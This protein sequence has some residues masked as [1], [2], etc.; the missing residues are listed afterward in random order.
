MNKNA[1]S[2][3]VLVVAAML[4]M[5]AWPA[6]KLASVQSKP[7]LTMGLSDPGVP[8]MTLPAAQGPG[9]LQP[10]VGYAI[11]SDLSPALR[12]LEPVLPEEGQTIREIPLRP[13]PQSR[14]PGAPTGERDPVVQSWPGAP[15]MPSPLKNWEG[16]NNRN[17]VYPP[18]TQGDI[19]DDPTT[20]KKYYVQWVNLSYAMWDVTGISPTLVLGPV[21]GN[22]LW[23]GFGG[24]CETTNHG[25]P[26]TLFD[27]LAHRWLMSQFSVNGP[28]H[29]CIAISQTGD[30]T[31]AWYRYDFLVHATKMNDYPK[32]G[33]WPDAYYMTV[34]QFNPG[35]AGA[36]VFAFNRAKMLV[37]DPTANFV[38][39]DLY[40]ANPNFGGMLPSDLDGDTPPPAGA[41][42]Y[43]AEVDNGSPD[44]M[45]L[46]KFHTDWTN[47]LSSTFG[48]NGQPNFVVPVADFNPLTS[49]IPQP[50][51]SQRLDSLADRLMHRLAYRNFGDHESLV[52]N[53]TVDA[54]ASRAGVRWY[55]VRDPGETP[56]IYQQ[57]TYAPADTEHRWMGSIAMDHMGN[58]ALGYSVSS[59]SVYPS[60]RYTGR[61][62][63]DPLG[64]LPQGETEIIAGSGVQTGPAGRWGDYSMMGVDPTDDCT[65]WYTQEYIQTTGTASWQTRIAAFKFPNC[66]LGPQGTLRGTVSNASN[67]NPIVGA[68]V[69]AAS[70]PIQTFSTSSGTGGGY[71]IVL[72]VNTYTVTGSAY[73]FRPAAI[74]GVSVVSGTTTTQ[75][76]QLTPVVMRV[77]SGTVTDAT[78]GWSLYAHITIQGDPFNPPPPYN[79][80]WTDPVTGHYSVTLA[81]GIT[82]T[83]NVNA[84]VT[85]Y[86]AAS[87]AVGPL[88]ANRTENFGLTV[89]SV[90]CNAPGYHPTVVYSE[91]FEASNGEYITTTP[92]TTSW[93]W[94]T[95]SAA[96]GLG[97]AHSG[98]KLWATNLTGNYN[99][100]EDG[101]TT[102]PNIDLG[103][104][105]G[106]SLLLSWWQWLQTESC[107]DYASVEV[108]KDGGATWA[109]VYGEVS[110]N[111]DLVWAQHSVTLDPTY[112]VSNF[113]VRF[114]LRTDY[115]VT[116][117]GWY[118]DDV[119]IRSASCIPQTGGLVVGNTFDAN[120]LAPLAGARVSN[121]SGRSTMTLATIDPNVPDSF[122]TMFSPSGSRV[123]T[124]TRTG[125]YVTSIQTPTVV[126]SSTIRQDFNL[127]AG[128]LSYTP[129]SLQ[130]ALTLGSSTSKPFTLTNSGG[131]SATFELIEL[132]KGMGPLG[133]FQKPDLVVKPFKQDRRTAQGLGLPDPPPAPPYAAGDVI[134]SWASGLAAAWGIAYDKNDGTVWVSSPAPSWSGN[135]TIYEFTPAGVQTGRSRL[136]SWNPTYGPADAAFNWNTG[137]LWIMNVDTAGANNC[138]YEIDPASGYTGNRIC[139]GGGFA[140]NQRGLAYDPSTDTW[141]A[142]SWND[143]MIHH[144]DST[145]VMLDEVNVGLGVAGLAYN[146]DTRHLFAIVNAN[147]NPVYVLDAANNYTSLG[148]F[149]I[150]GF[151]ANSGA[152]LEIGCDGH[153]WAVNQTS[154]AVYEVD[155][156]ETTS[157]CARDVPWLSESPISGTLAALANQPIAVT[158]DAS[159]VAQP[160]QY[161]AQLKIKHN[162]P[163]VVTNVPVTLTVPP[164][165]NWGKLTGTVT[166]LARCDAS[167]P[168]LNN[169]TVLFQSSAGMTWT[170]TT[171]AG[172]QYEW[173]MDQANNPLSM[174]VSHAG[175]ITQT[176]TGIAVTAQ[177]TTTQDVSLRLAVPC[178]SVNPAGLNIRGVPGL[179]KT[180][181]LTI[182]NSGGG[183]AD[184]ALWEKSN[185][186]ASPIAVAVFNHITT[187]DISY[188]TGS[189]SNDWSLYQ[190]ILTSDV[191]SRF[192]VTVV[193]NLSPATLTGFDRLILPD[194]AVPDV[195][196]N[197]VSSWFT[198][199][200]RIIAVDSAT[201]YAAYSGFMWP[202]SAGSNGNGVYWDY[203]SGSDDQEVLRFDRI[204]RD[205][206]V[207]Q[208]LSAYGGDSE[209]FAS[210]L[211]GPTLQ[212]TAKHWDHSKVYVASRDVPGKGTI[213][214]LGPYSPLVASNLYALVRNAVAGGTDVDVPWLSE[215]PVSSTVGA[216][217]I[218]PVNITLTALPMMTSGAYTTTLA[219]NT[220]DIGNVRVNIPVTMTIVAPP[221]CSFTSSSPDN[222]GEV[223]SFVNATTG[224]PPISYQWNFGDSSTVSTAANPT[225]RYPHVGLYTVILTATNAVST[226]VC[227]STVSIVNHLIYLPVVLRN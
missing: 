150:P 102:S 200:K 21:N 96:P 97:S 66:A 196:T 182:T 27:P 17:G 22:T 131:A 147:P 136:F 42:N 159:Q 189:N 179:S 75:N 56:V 175:H 223:T 226:D 72:P 50:G 220:G 119:Q 70:S 16:V 188:W 78:T 116:Y 86:N 91:T 215:N 61:L 69:Q 9:F 115:S 109:R 58:M 20:N 144:F 54:G 225:Y 165:A 118:V 68:Q 40:G 38:Y 39:F 211:P 171:D 76:I 152:G 51:T 60:I 65:F 57:G 143:S 37:G 59:N 67:G 141:Y 71:S 137:M 158:F 87:H 43:F 203:G 30:P 173:W 167:G 64:T 176:I 138:I 227:T 15:N 195:Y 112:A 25:D 128:R 48:V 142:G 7:T 73:G 199:G 155:S 193:T 41:P 11:K 29:Q 190:N 123:F 26:I 77:V 53:H 49:L 214:V 13:L 224:D 146:P 90:T 204:T 3:N 33:V 166:G 88:T 83:F 127:P 32:F 209:M 93:A 46:W 192:V 145:G 208:V 6:P 124:A 178:V 170:L 183:P 105:A 169:A 12:D 205:Y 1:I 8:P 34:N 106:Q 101:Y 213:V 55:E 217:A 129:A 31:G 206:G 36:G 19:G 172:G 114:R 103:T 113:R 210:G 156:G 132:D 80:L 154:E 126:Q 149:T 207:G 107:C 180:V 14:P 23:A 47:P 120:T 79:D 104:Y 161:R 186:P 125:G 10:V 162:T 108:S 130:A 164:P 187:T 133:P 99:N 98:A 202:A 110:G 201:T 163:Y 148:Q 184:W 84:W 139:P 45:R 134:Q 121:D 89:D 212:L 85:G 24:V 191:E 82:Y 140:N 35:W 174:T 95:P 216:D 18:D 160:G 63:S 100:N 52:V 185:A 92:S 157:V 94:G 81:E 198:P 74:S 28:Y 168:P 222:L 122:Y 111:I 197:S 4:V 5:T 219:I 2:V 153:L 221:Y 135:N 151:D 177:Q 194:N 62:S 44:A 218:F 181:S 117:P